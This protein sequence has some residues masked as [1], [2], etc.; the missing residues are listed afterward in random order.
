M[1][2]LSK[3]TII[4]DFGT[5]TKEGHLKDSGLSVELERKDQLNFPLFVMLK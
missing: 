2:A 3:G 1:E 5:R 4:R